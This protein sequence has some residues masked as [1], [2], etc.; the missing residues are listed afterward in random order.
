MKLTQSQRD[1]IVQTGLEFVG[2][3]RLGVSCD[4]F[5]RKIFSMADI[6]LSFE[7][8]PTFF[9]AEIFG[10]KAVGYP[11]FLR[12]KASEKGKRITH[13][14]IIFPNERVLHYSRWMRGTPEFYEV[15]LSTFEEV[16]AIYDF[17]EPVR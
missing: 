10:E 4:G 12:R 3:R 9:R 2:K 5:V 14:G 16:F 8:C 11:I 17:V 7:S 15:C 1:T 13:M 6:D